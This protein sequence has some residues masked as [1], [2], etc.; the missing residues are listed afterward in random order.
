MC[1]CL[2]DS[3]E[4]TRKAAKLDSVRSSS[5]V[6]AAKIAAE[7]RSTA[8]LLILRDVAFSRAA[9]TATA[10]ATDHVILVGVDCH[11]ASGILTT[12][13]RAPSTVLSLL[14]LVGF[15]PALVL[16]TRLQSRRLNS[17]RSRHCRVREDLEMAAVTAIE[18]LI[19]TSLERARTS[20]TWNAHAR[21]ERPSSQQCLLQ[22]RYHHH[23]HHH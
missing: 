9:A 14:L 15:T 1:R 13:E 8:V 2:C 4:A 6:Q 21:L 17:C 20:G 5:A 12:Y 16:T 3:E 10:T 18:K 7:K 23:L 19:A 22:Y 11:V